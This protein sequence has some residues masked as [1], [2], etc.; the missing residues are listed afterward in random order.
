[1]GF[2]CA[3][4]LSATWNPGYLAIRGVLS[5]D[6]ERPAV[7]ETLDAHVAGV[8]ILQARKE[9]AGAVHGRARPPPDA[10]LEDLRAAH[11]LP[12]RRGLVLGDH[13]REAVWPK[14]HHRHKKAR[15]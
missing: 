2:G 12:S 1:M 4:L 14:S 3:L 13:R 7:P 6:A 10:E 9:R 11:Q 5:V 15:Q 8:E